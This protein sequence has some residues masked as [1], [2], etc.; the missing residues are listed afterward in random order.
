MKKN[1]LLALLLLLILLSGIAFKPHSTE[2]SYVS[3]YTRR[4]AQFSESLHNTQTS[5]NEQTLDASLKKQ[6][7]ERILVLREKL[8][9]LDFWLRY[10]HP[11]AYKK[12]N[13][14]LTV[15]WETE[16]FEKFEK[17]YRREGAGLSLAEL[18]LQEETISKDSLE[19]L[20]ASAE[21]A[22]ALFQSDSIMNQ[23]NDAA[24]FYFCNRLFLLNLAT[25]YTSGFECPNT[26][27]V[28]PELR[29][30]LQSVETIYTFYSADHKSTALS[31]EYLQCFR[32][33]R[34]FVNEQPEN[35]TLFNHFQFM[36]D[37]VNPL[38]QINQA[39][40][41]NYH[42]KSKS[43]V[44]YSLNLN[45]K[46]IFSKDLY[47]AQNTKG[48]Y[49]RITDPILLEQIKTLGQTLF[50]DPILSG[51]NLRA[52]S[53]CHQANQ[54]FTDTTIRTAKHFNQSD[55]LPRTTPSLL[56]AS[57]QHLIMHDGHINTLQEQALA[58]ITNTAEMA[59]SSR[60][61]LYKIK[62][63]KDYAQA[64][65]QLLP[66]TPQEPKLSMAHITSALTYY[67]GSFSSALSPFDRAM[68]NKKTIDSSVEHGYN[69]FMSKAQCGTC[70][71]A[72]QF[73]GVKPPYVSSEFEVLGVPT[74]TS[75][76]AISEDQG[77]YQVNAAP[78]TKHAFRTSTLRNVA[79][80]AP[81]MHN[82]VF[83]NLTELIDFYDAGGAS[84]H[85]LKLDNQS[86]SKDSL[87]LTEAEKKD[88]IAFMTALTEELPKIDV[89]SILP[90]SKIK[91]LNTRKIGGT[92]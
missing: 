66:F 16:V 48:V 55:D 22:L 58:V 20:F 76:A 79:R 75:Y 41:Q 5:L 12:I 82:G 7:L 92:Y 87:K 35:A 85:G 26:N 77:R 18:Y 53:S 37:Y 15:E 34:Q 72:P 50:F 88:L 4:V 86:L 67:Y 59:C 91:S 10:L 64:F 17:P 13:G 54:Y 28:I 30:M 42:L 24:N 19:H 32:E 65:K 73:N 78:E 71:F 6:V 57:F 2:S 74:N 84:G 70:H 90:K 49:A 29:Q 33:M 27:R 61:L 21:S 45:C 11:L 51:N 39:L 1:I 69:V 81:Y 9:T 80:T 56:N 3:L 60:D 44:D 68:T 25:I 46:S 23:V 63:C 40:I 36:R 47:R 83:R 89:P 38:Y 14:P 52:C 43:L 62:S 31:T 8:K